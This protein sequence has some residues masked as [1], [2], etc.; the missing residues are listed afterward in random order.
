MK[1][2]NLKVLAILVA[3]IVG[4]LVGVF[5]LRR[6]QVSRNAG[7][8]AKLAKQRLEEGKPAEAVALYGRYLGLRPEDNEAYAAFAKLMLARAESPNAT[9]NDLGRAYNTLE[10]ALRRDPENDDLRRQLAKF[11]L[12]IGR[13]SDAREHLDILRERLR[14]GTVQQPDAKDSLDGTEVEAIDTQA[15]EL[16]MARS[17]LGVGDVGEAGKIVAEMVGFDLEAR[18]FVED[19]DLTGPTEAYV[20][21]AAILEEKLDNV[22]AATKVLEKMVEKHADDVQAWLARSNWHRQR[23][24]LDAAAADIDAA[25]KINPDDI[26]GLFAAFELALARKDF[27]AAK[28]YAERGL[29]VDPDDERAY[30]GLAAVSMQAGALEEAE[31]LLLDGIERLPAKASLLLMLADVLLQQNKIEEVRQAIDRIKELY[32]TSSP[33][34]G[35]LE[36]R[37][38]VAQGKWADAKEQLESVRPLVLG[39]PDLVRQVDL[40]LGQCHAQLDEYDA[41]LDVNRRVLADDPGS[42]AARAGTA[43]A[44]A[45]AG[46]PA[47]ALAEFEAIA[48]ALPPERLASV[49]QVWYPLLQLRMQQQAKRPVADR[50]WGAVDDLLDMLEQSP[51]MSATQITLLRADTLVRKG[52]QATAREI[53]EAEAAREPNPQVWAALITLAL[54]TATIDEAEALL[55]KVPAEIADS[56]IMLTIRGQ[57]ASQRGGDAGK[58][59]LAEIEKLTAKLP[60]IEAGSVLAALAGLQFTTGDSETFERLWRAVAQRKPDD[61]RAREALLELAINRGAM[62]DARKVADEVA[63]VAGKGSARALVAEASV[64]I[65]EVRQGRDRRQAAEGAAELTDAEQRSLDE[66]RN[67]LIEAE[68]E[69]PGWGQLQTL[70]AEIDSIRGDQQAAAARLKKAI[71][72]GPPNPALVRRLVA[73]LYSLNRL[74]EA[75]AALGD[76]GTGG[77]LGMDRISAEMQL[78][79][80][81]SDEAV[82]VA[83]RTINE[84]TAGVED[85]LW[86]GQVLDRAGKQERA[87]DVL[88]KATEKGPDRPETW[89]ALFSHQVKIG[90]K[91]AAQQSLEKA[92]ALQE[93]PQREMTLA[94]GFEALGDLEAAEKMFRAACEAK[95]DDLE[96]QRGFASFLVRAGKFAPARETLQKMIDAPDSPANGEVKPWAR[97]LLAELIADRGN[98]REMGK[99]MQILNA[100]VDE[101]G[102]VSV[103]DM[104][105]KV[106]LLSSR[107]EPESWKKAI[108]ELENLARRQ[109]LV[110]GQRIMLAQLLEKVGRWSEARNELVA[111][112]AAPTV[113]PAYVAMLVEKLIDHGELDT[114]RPW[115]ARLARSTPGAAITLALEAK[116]A[117]AENNRDLAKEAARK[118]MPGGVVSGS[119][120]GQLAAVARLM[121][122][123]GFPKAADKVF[124]QFAE[125]SPDGVTARA[126]FLGR[127]KRVDEAL[128]LL[129]AR[130][131]DLPLERL[132][133]TAVQ[134]ARVQDDPTVVVERLDRWFSKGRRI[135]PGSIVIL[136]LEGERASLAGNDEG[137][138]KI[139]RELMARS[140]LD[141]TQRAIVANNLAFHL[142]DPATVAEAKKLIDEAISELGPLPDLLDTR[143]MIRMAAGETAEAIQDFEEAVLQP[144]DVKFL[145]LAWA[146]FKSGD[147]AK[148]KL[149]LEAGMRR[150][151]S[152][153]KLGPDDR[154]L[155]KELETTLGVS[156]PT[157]EPQG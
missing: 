27:E 74:D 87:G 142:A 52:E 131:N 31:Q 39:S 102:D 109:P 123:L 82:A 38:L 129:E 16:L 80:G 62:D 20:I 32:G 135:D 150:G 73:I 40:Y 104:L 66:A 88:V 121:E 53:L 101:K 98:F 115:L 64:K 95:P 97:R 117:I 68:S 154:A 137:A 127:Q 69:R 99:A 152:L 63:S 126:E 50:D 103:D 153:S 83:E 89:L 25:M 125:T 51:D 72:L 128:E 111:V 54:R 112:V 118:L 75:Q 130:W 49:P 41:Q 146:Q 70:F 100:N 45:A 33:A 14:E 9:R 22:G 108:E 55:A 65:F 84:E 119:E 134:I 2:I 116:L 149:S 29:E 8:L 11:Q 79:A 86:F 35:L 71:E 93:Q 3:T 42:L 60:D 105:L 92:A 46:K 91:P 57:V 113:P 156:E 94:Q 106:K 143:G 110:M 120:P 21:L 37:L 151:L 34:V 157:L 4:L 5:M 145:H 17:Y 144:T 24:K 28:R 85:L 1:R 18:A 136:L 122:Q 30:R 6:F 12:R 155:L 139:Y 59:E 43:S 107:P 61:I 13:A 36:G 96:T 132:L 140:D 58:A 67:M 7:N 124:S 76:L 147:S 141:P 56:A 19:R 138:E 90:R 23:G 44:L 26:N 48:S 10:E 15:I 133:T 148:A 78:R 77:E 81:R 47:E 114:A